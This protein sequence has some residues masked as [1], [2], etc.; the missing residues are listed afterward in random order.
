MATGMS[1]KIRSVAGLPPLLLLLRRGVTTQYIA[2][3]E[4]TD[5]SPRTGI[6]PTPP[7]P[8]PGTRANEPSTIA[9]RARAISSIVQ[10]TLCTLTSRD[11]VGSPTLN[12]WRR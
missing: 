8:T 6:I 10:A 2:V 7:A 5:R 9:A 1:R 4:P 11:A 3:G 12:R